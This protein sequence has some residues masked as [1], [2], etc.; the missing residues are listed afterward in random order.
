LQVEI[1]IYPYRDSH[2]LTILRCRRAFILLGEGSGVFIETIAKA[3]H[4]TDN[5]RSAIGANDDIQ[6]HGTLNSL[7]SSFI[8]IGRFNRG[9]RTGRRSH[10]APYTLHGLLILLLRESRRLLRG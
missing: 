9:T 5:F 1:Y 7:T 6:C 8:R 4:N 10:T 3:M 2:G